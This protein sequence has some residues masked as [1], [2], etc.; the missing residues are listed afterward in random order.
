MSSALCSAAIDSSSLT[1]PQV[2][3]IAQAPKLTLETCQPV[4]PNSRYCMVFSSRWSARVVAR[5]PVAD[6]SVARPID[7]SMVF[8]RRLGGARQFVGIGDR[9]RRE[10]E[11]D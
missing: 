2:P 8:L 5:R 4:R 7:Q 6:P 1:V 3:P 9:D 10:Q 11:G